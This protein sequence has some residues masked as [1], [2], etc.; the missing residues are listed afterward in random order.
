MRSEY[1]LVGGDSG[2]S[3]RME[4]VLDGDVVG[5]FDPSEP[6]E[7]DEDMGMMVAD[8]RCRKK[9]GLD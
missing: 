7:E 4:F 8:F 6:D 1:S 9:G 3:G 5:V 2:R